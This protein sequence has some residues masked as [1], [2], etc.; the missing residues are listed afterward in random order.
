MY[1]TLLKN[2][3][4]KTKKFLVKSMFMNILTAGIFAFAFAACSDD[5]EMGNN[6]YGETQS[7][8]KETLLE[9]YGLTYQTFIDENDV[10]ILDKDTTQLSISK[11]YADKLGITSFVNHPMGIWHNQ[12]QL[13]YIRK[14]IAEQLVNG[15]YIVSVKPATLAEVIGDK[16]VNLQTDIYVNN[17]P[18]SVSTRAAGNNIPEYAAKYVDANNVIHPAVIHLTDPYG[19]EE[20]VHYPGD[21]PS[22]SQTRAAQTGEYQYITAEE[23]AAGNTRFGLRKRLLAFDN[24]FG[25][26][27]KHAA[28]GSS[29]SIYVAYEIKSDFELNYFLT[30]EGGLKWSGFIPSPYVKKFETGV[31]GHF[32]FGAKVEFGVEREWKLKEEDGKIPLAKFPGYT[33]SFF[34]G[35][36]PVAIEVK[37]NMFMQFDGKISGALRTGFSYEYGNKFMGGGRYTE[38]KGWE[39]IGYFEETK[40][41]FKMYPPQININ[42][43]CGVGIFLGADILVYKCAGPDFAAGPRLGATL[44]ITVSPFDAKDWSDIVQVE[45]EVKLDIN[46]KLGAKLTLFGYEL[47]ETEVNIPMAGPWTLAKYPSD[48]SEHKVGDK[49]GVHTT[50]PMQTEWKNFYKKVGPSFTK[51]MQSIINMLKEINGCDAAKARQTLINRLQKGYDSEPAYSYA[52]YAELCAVLTEYMNEVEQMYY[53]YQYQK[54]GETGNM[55]WIYAANWQRIIKEIKECGCR[56][57]SGDKEEVA[58][59]NIHQWFLSEFNRE[60]NITSADDMSWI[61]KKFIYYSQYKAEYEYKK[62]NK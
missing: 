16:K 25:N 57:S 40:N 8:G 54:A 21:K 6:P 52:I 41:E 62:R 28:K 12:S 14:A 56:L 58:W 61:K 32:D 31:D 36:V 24:S 48:G 17:N 49:N 23:M 59:N 34:V 27:F 15:R 33:Y 10:Q 30:L 3:T 45:G 7:Q 38:S 37:P 60:P 51:D 20:D 1:Y 18:S 43:E 42:M 19:Y 47:A 39:G 2:L 29:D 44:D 26:K 55:E 22:A 4:M 9:A 5:L 50:D 46:A 11:A 53:D 35:P 13:P